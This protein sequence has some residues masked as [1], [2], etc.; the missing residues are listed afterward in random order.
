VH[1][2][3]GLVIRA[4]GV[5]GEVLLAVRTD[6]PEAR[7]RVGA[8]YPTRPP[9]AGPLTIAGLR[10]HTSSGADRMLVVFEGVH[11]RDGAERLRGVELLVDPA[12]VP[13]T[14]DPDEFHDFQL[15]GLAVVVGG[16]GVDGYP[17]GTQVG[18]ISR[19]NHGPGADML[20]VRR[21]DDRETL[22]P[23]VAAMVPTVD[24]AG[25]RVVITPPVGLLDL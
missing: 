24:L 3:V 8:V 21:A 12:D 19:I 18:V 20:I 2:V 6:E 25:G 22:V 4:H 14:D 5:R 13:P 16:E 7:F 23:F 11:D 10:T 1:L 17:A 9:S 15:V